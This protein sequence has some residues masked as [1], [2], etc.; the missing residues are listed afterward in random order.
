MLHAETN[1]LTAAQGRGDTIYVTHMPCTNCLGH[2]IQAGIKVVVTRE[3]DYS[4]SKWNA[5]LVLD[6][7]DEAGI[8][9]IML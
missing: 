7:A 3:R 9:I 4:K 5:S 6:L 2:I 8:E 1:A